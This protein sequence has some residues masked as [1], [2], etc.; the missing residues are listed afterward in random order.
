MHGKSVAQVVLRWLIQ[1]DVIVIPKSVRL[2][3]MRE[4]IDVFDVE[5]TDHEMG[6]IA[7]MDTG[8]TPFLRRLNG[9]RARSSRAILR[10][11]V[12][13]QAAVSRR[14]LTSQEVL[15][16]IGSRHSRTAARDL[17]L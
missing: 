6:R 5:L 17:P 11:R 15:A 7:A 10:W 12:R 1:R 16:R 9:R 8:T 2:E 14:T 3:R 4:N 13:A